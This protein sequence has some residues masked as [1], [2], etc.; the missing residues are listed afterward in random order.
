MQACLSRLSTTETLNTLG[1]GLYDGHMPRK[2][3]VEPEHTLKLNREELIHVRDLFS[4]LVQPSKTI[5]QALAQASKT[6]TS[7]S[8]LI[9]WKKIMTACQD[10]GIPLGT[11]APDFAVAMT[12]VPQLD[13]FRAEVRGNK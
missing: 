13:V 11:T 9:L 5:S 10:A 8:E 6:S 12:E 2:P 1:V 3:A 4:V 7:E